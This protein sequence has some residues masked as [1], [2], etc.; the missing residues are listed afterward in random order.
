MRPTSTA[1]LLEGD[2]AL[3]EA[4]DLEEVIDEPLQ[5]AQLPL[6]AGT[7]V[8]DDGDRRAAHFQDFGVAHKDGERVAQFMAEHGQELVLLAVVLQQFL[9]LV[10]QDRFQSLTLGDLAF[11]QVL[12]GQRLYGACSTR[13]CARCMTSQMRPMQTPT[14]PKPAVSIR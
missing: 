12:P 8:V 7:D 14:N 1:F 11:E 10:P 9:G 2:L 5:V 3:H 6:H 13:R 4:A